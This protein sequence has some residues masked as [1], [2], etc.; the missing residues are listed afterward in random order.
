MELRPRELQGRTFDKALQSLVTYLEERTGVTV[1]LHVEVE[2]VELPERYAV[3]LWH[4]FQEAFSNIEKYAHATKVTITLDVT[5]GKL[6]LDICDD[7]IGFELEK[8]E[9]GRGYGLSNIKDRSE[10]LGGILDIDT[11]LGKGTKLLIR[12]PYYG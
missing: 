11:A 9:G 8:A 10:K 5:G 2:L 12:I 1:D 7:G 6:N 4:I 3:N